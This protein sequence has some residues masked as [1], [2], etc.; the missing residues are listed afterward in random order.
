MWSGPRLALQRRRGPLCSS[1]PQPSRTVGNLPTVDLFASEDFPNAGTM[2]ADRLADFCQRRSGLLRSGEGL[3]PRL[4][5]SLH[6]SL[7][8]KLCALRL[9][10]RLPFGIFRHQGSLSPSPRRVRF[11]AY[12]ANH[13]GGRQSCKGERLL[14]AGARFRPSRNRWRGSLVARW[15]GCCRSR[16]IPKGHDP[17]RPS[18][19]RLPHSA[20]SIRQ[21][22]YCADETCR[23]GGRRAG[24]SPTPGRSGSDA[25][26]R[27]RE[28]G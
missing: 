7:V 28:S 25:S 23:A 9:G 19:H 17:G 24:R 4:P 27:D 5:R 20:W 3:A 1:G 12:V 8:V 18:G 16:R 21:H 10:E 14:P 22:L 13:G 11:Q 2:Q 6:V 26:T 15:G